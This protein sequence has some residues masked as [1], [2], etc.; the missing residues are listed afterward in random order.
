MKTKNAIKFILFVSLAVLSIAGAFRVLKWKD[1]SGD[2]NSS[3]EQLKNTPRDTVD[4]VFTGSSHTYC[5]IAPAT[6]WSQEG[7]S[8]F[9]MAISG[10]DKYSSYHSLKELLKTQSPEVVFVD[11]YPFT[12]EK[13]AVEGNEHRNMM[14]LPTGLNSVEQLKDYYDISEKEERTKIVNYFLRWP[15]VHTR[16]RELGKYDYL[17]N[18]ANDFIRGEGLMFVANPAEYFDPSAY[19]CEAAELSDKNMQLIDRF[20]ELSEKENFSLVFIVIPYH[21][22]DTDLSILDGAISYIEGKNV[23]VVD[24]NRGREVLN[25]DVN[26]DFIDND[27]L[28]GYGA[29]KLSS[30]LT[31]YLKENYNLSDHRGDSAYHQ[32]DEDYA[33][34]GKLAFETVLN[35]CESL[36]ETLNMLRDQKDYTTVVSLELDYQNAEY[37][38]LEDLK[39]FGMNEEEFSAAG[40]WVYD[41]G[42]LKRI[43]YNNP[44]APVSTYPLGRYD[45][46]SA[47]FHGDLQPENVMISTTDISNCGY[48]LKLTVYDKTLER[49]AFQRGF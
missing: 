38:Y 27:H 6:F 1:T 48:Y 12:Y 32:W 22:G 4:V 7:Y 31:A 17:K 16:Y 45:T 26:T 13:H 21:S 24:L 41:N 3:I 5:G 23:P 42:G 15:I 14:A 39:I 8:V 35:Q 25:L 46:L 28:N 19:V 2:Y 29:E 20:I 30:Y 47:S 33:Y 36:P 49:V 11:L 37:P 34:C 44:E 18:P 43:S 10:Q 9:D 40:V